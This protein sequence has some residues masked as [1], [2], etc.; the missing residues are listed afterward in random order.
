MAVCV[1]YRVIF[2]AR[3]Y[4]VIRAAVLNSTK[5]R[6]LI[7]KSNRTGVVGSFLSNFNVQIDVENELFFKEYI[8]RKLGWL[9]DY[10]KLSLRF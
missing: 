6:K 4:N 9:V 10:L 2:I 3:G 1:I 8:Y 7:L 5:R